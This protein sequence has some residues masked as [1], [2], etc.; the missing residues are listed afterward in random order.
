MRENLLHSQ[1]SRSVK[2]PVLTDEI[3]SRDTR[4]QVILILTG[5]DIHRRSLTSNFSEA[6]DVKTLM[7]KI[8]A[9][10]SIYSWETG[11]VRF[12]REKRGV[13]VHRQ[14]KTKWKRI[15]IVMY[16]SN[17]DKI[18]EYREYAEL[19]PLIT[20]P[21]IPILRREIDTYRHD[22]STENARYFRERWIFSFTISE[23]RV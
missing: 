7:K 1:T 11:W 19:I 2:A 9:R 22:Q 18:R 12:S 16:R 13:S 3:A 5:L 20:I 15:C 4:A 10:D 17:D 21:L 14:W 23:R 8:R 6:F